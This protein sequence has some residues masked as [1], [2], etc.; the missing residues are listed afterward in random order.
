M[1]LK[2]VIAIRN[3]SFFFYMFMFHLL[4]YLREKGLPNEP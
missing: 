1:Q 2:F 3:P 4:Q